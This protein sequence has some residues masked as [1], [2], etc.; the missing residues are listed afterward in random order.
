MTDTSFEAAVRA[1][2]D[3]PTAYSVGLITE[4]DGV[5][6]VAPLTVGDLRLALH[7]DE[8]QPH[9]VLDLLTRQRMLRPTGGDS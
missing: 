9:E 8:I 2:D 6:P 4:L 3:L 5:T 7:R 1:L